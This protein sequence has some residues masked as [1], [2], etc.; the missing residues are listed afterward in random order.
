[1]Q[2]LADAKTATSSYKLIYSNLDQ[3]NLDGYSLDSAGY[4]GRIFS[5][6]GV[7]AASGEPYYGTGALGYKNSD[8]T[9]NYSSTISQ[10]INSAYPDALLVSKIPDVAPDASGILQAHGASKAVFFEDP[11]PISVSMQNV[12]VDNVSISN[13]HVRN[14][15]NRYFSGVINDAGYDIAI[16]FV[17]TL[18]NDV[19]FS[20]STT[21]RSLLEKRG[22]R[23]GNVTFN[24]TPKDMNAIWQAAINITFMYKPYS[25]SVDAR[26]HV[27]NMFLHLL[28][29]YVARMDILSRSVNHEFYRDIPPYSTPVYLNVLSNP[30]AGYVTTGNLHLS[31]GVCHIPYL[32]MQ[33]YATGPLANNWPMTMFNGAINIIIPLDTDQL[34]PPF[35][36]TGSYPWRVGNNAAD[37]VPRN[38]AICSS[39]QISEI[40]GKWINDNDNLSLADFTHIPCC[41]LGETVISTNFTE[42]S[43]AFTVYGTIIKGIS[44]SSVM[45]SREIFVSC[46]PTFK[47]NGVAKFYKSTDSV[48]A[49][50]ARAAAATVKLDSVARETIQKSGNLVKSWTT[51]SIS[52]EAKHNVKPAVISK[53]V[54]LR[55]ASRLIKDKGPYLLAAADT[56]A[57]GATAIGFPEVG[58]VIAG[59]AGLM[60]SKG[61]GALNA[62]YNVIT[63]H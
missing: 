40:A 17:W 55:E 50:P 59:A 16:P 11:C 20:P 37:M 42:I 57:I 12:D 33:R 53:A 23:D 63:R 31:D 52:K 61:P 48:D 34:D 25:A 62:F 28:G 47:S 45:C 15:C 36:S 2:Y 46:F 3:A 54:V 1:L 29:M 27:Y 24:E 49:Y 43:A 38:Y 10:I 41:C 4:N 22:C 58:A 39:G 21:W 26:N 9:D 19:P 6:V 18:M 5:K 13:G 56:V 7:D 60:I 51:I 30:L 32:E 35:T 44:S 8:L 14:S